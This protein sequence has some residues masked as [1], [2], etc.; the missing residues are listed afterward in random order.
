[1]HKI[2]APDHVGNLFVN[3]NPGIGQPATVLDADWLNMAQT[4]L[5]SVLIS[6]G[7]V[8]IKGTNNQLRDA[9]RRIAYF[10]GQS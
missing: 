9:V 1:M 4:E 2:D 3:G 10:M 7:I 6:A 8:P 5:L